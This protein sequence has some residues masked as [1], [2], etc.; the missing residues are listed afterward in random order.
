MA[1]LCILLIIVGVLLNITKG[2]CKTC[3]PGW[4]LIRSN[5]YYF[6]TIRENW[7]RSKELCA[8]RNGIL[9]VIKDESEMSSLWTFIQQ[10]AFWIGLRRDPKDIDMWVWTDG[11][12]LTYSA[13]YED[14]PNNV[15]K[16]EHCVE[17]WGA[18]QSWND[19][20]CQEKRNYICRGVWSC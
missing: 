2:S 18:V 10:E 9:V 17:T 20:P 1:L 16:N 11:S 5:C 15:E 6:S 3:P 7:E 19:R 12:P 14:E 4:N 13:W 8:E